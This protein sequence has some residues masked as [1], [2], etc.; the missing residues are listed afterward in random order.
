M[1]RPG[2]RTPFLPGT[3]EKL[4]V[5]RERKRLRQPLTV[6][7]DASLDDLRSGLVGH[8]DDQGNDHVDG[9]RDLSLSN[10]FDTER[11]GQQLQRQRLRRNLTVPELSRASGIHRDSI[12]RLEAGERFPTL[13]TL[14][15]LAAALECPLARLVG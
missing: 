13:A 4:H 11:F 10:G 15:R 3:P 6:P 5:I 7:G 8:R 14:I 1:A 9:Q 2:R 12:Y